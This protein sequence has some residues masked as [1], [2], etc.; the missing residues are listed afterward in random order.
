V[1]GETAATLN[2]KL[3]DLD[4]VVVIDWWWQLALFSREVFYLHGN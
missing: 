3:C 2:V 1:V 4:L